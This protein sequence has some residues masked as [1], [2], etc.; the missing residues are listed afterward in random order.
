[1]LRRLQC[2]SAG[3]EPAILS[4]MTEATLADFYLRCDPL[5]RELYSVMSREWQ[6]VGQ[7][8]RSDDAGLCLYLRSVRVGDGE[9]LPLFCLSP[10]AGRDPATIALQTDTWRE[11][12]GEEQVDAM[13]RCI[14]AIDGIRFEERDG[15][16]SIVDPGHMSG[17]MQQALRDVILDMARRG[18]DLIAP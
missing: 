13:L 14:Q 4:A 6:E 8:V 18:S 10:G 15:R 9:G 12:F 2:S 3:I 11:W 16:F 5:H 7:A 1:M 17:P